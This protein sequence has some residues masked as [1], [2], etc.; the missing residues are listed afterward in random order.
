MLSFLF[1][2]E[3]HLDGPLKGKPL[4]YRLRGSMGFWKEQ[5]VDKSTHIQSKL[6]NNEIIFCVKIVTQI[7]YQKKSY[8]F[9][10]QILPK[11]WSMFRKGW[12]Y[13]QC[14]EKS[15]KQL[16]SLLVKFNFKKGRKMFCNYMCTTFLHQIL[17]SFRRVQ[18]V[19]FCCL[20]IVSLYDNG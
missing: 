13:R 7:L 14:W 2:F 17:V 11:S 4:H 9:R 10:K 20:T 5:K 3:Y 16:L 8:L 1:I 15:S 19:P 12:K 6:S 18:L